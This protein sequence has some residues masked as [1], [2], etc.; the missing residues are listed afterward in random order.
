L[1]GRMFQVPGAL[2]SEPLGEKFLDGG[3]QAMVGHQRRP[4]R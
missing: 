4:G 1:R 3:A 2:W